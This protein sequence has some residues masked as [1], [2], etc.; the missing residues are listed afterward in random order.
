MTGNY[1]L[2]DLFQ[3]SPRIGEGFV[4]GEG[5]ERGGMEGSC[6]NGEVWERQSPKDVKSSRE[7]RS[8]QMGLIG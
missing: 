2:K 6:S 3:H 7:S 4:M 8:G 5:E 1:V